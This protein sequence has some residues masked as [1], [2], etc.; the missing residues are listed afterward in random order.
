MKYESLKRLDHWDII[1]NVF[2]KPGCK[3]TGVYNLPGILTGSHQHKEKGKFKNEKVKPQK[4]DSNKTN[5]EKQLKVYSLICYQ[6]FPLQRGY[7]GVREGK[8][9]SLFF[10]SVFFCIYLNFMYKTMYHV[11]F[12]QLKVTLD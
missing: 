3:A 11:Q 4:Q 2:I 10:V 9:R 7:S 6:C 12:M 1:K 8:Q 5:L